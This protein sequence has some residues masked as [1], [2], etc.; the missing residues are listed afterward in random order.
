MFRAA[1]GR[2]RIAEHPFP[3]AP[4]K[5]FKHEGVMSV[6]S[7]Y[8]GRLPRAVSPVVDIGARRIAR[9]SMRSAGGEPQYLVSLPK[10]L[11]HLWAGLWGERREVRV[12]LDLLG[13]NPSAGKRRP[14]ALPGAVTPVIDLGARRI[15]RQGARSADGGPRFALLLPHSLNGVW[16]EAWSSGGRARVVLEILGREEVEK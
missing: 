8:S 12:V 10:Q 16:G 1:R 11:N 3:G 2:A 14:N 7:P 13:A 9:R 4:Y 15:A 6:E 5:A